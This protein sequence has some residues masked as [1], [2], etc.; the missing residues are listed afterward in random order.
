MR[1]TEKMLQKQV[2]TLN[3][4]TGKSGHWSEIDAYVLDGAY[5]GV[6]LHQYVNENG[7]VNDVFSSGH[8]PKKELSGRIDAYIKGIIE[9]KRLA[10][11]NIE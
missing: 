2:D 7:A 9:G 11:E 10:L 5:G 6:A 3:K 4:I 1:I 8:M